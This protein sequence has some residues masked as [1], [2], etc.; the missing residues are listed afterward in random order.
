[1]R[2]LILF[3]PLFLLACSEAPPPETDTSDD[4]V[5][6]EETRFVEELPTEGGP[7]NAKR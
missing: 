1:M 7:E 6:L 4:S 2:K 5:V 3:A